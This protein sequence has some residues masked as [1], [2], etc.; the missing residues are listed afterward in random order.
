MARRRSPPLTPEQ[1]RAVAKLRASGVLPRQ[2]SDRQSIDIIEDPPDAPTVA[3]S[4]LS[5]MLMDRESLCD[6]MRNFQTMIA[7]G[8]LNR[9]RGFNYPEDYVDPHL[10]PEQIA[11]FGK[12]LAQLSREHE[13]I[14]ARISAL[15]HETAAKK[16]QQTFRNLPP[17]PPAMM[18]VNI[19]QGG[20]VSITPNAASSGS[21]REIGAAPV[22]P[23]SED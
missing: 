15:S 18:Q 11:D 3:R 4:E 8:V 12:T 13:R 6:S 19:Q 5:R 22:A 14:S 17:Q 16:T 23:D 9:I 21:V 20:A 7:N 1:S 10:T 2:W